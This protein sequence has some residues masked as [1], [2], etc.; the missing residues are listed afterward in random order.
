ME[1]VGVRLLVLG[2]KRTERRVKCPNCKKQIGIE[3]RQKISG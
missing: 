3:T 2:L 1:K